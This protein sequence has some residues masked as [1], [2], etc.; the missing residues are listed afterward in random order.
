MW[1]IYVTFENFAGNNRNIVIIHLRNYSEIRNCK[2]H[3]R[4][5]D[6]YSGFKISWNLLMTTLR[7]TGVGTSGYR[8]TVLHY[9]TTC[10]NIHS[11]D[12]TLIYSTWHSTLP[13]YISTF[14]VNLCQ[15]Q[16]Q[17]FIIHCIY[18]ILHSV[19]TFYS[20]NSKFQ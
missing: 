2:R 11:S 6:T 15:K 4:Q 19:T 18:L 3:L 9:V 16:Q 12:I 10:Y 17:C 5:E 13:A 7:F 8:I 20:G 14:Y 1:I